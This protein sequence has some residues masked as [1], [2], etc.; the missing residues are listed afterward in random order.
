MTLINI[1]DGFRCMP[2]IMTL[3]DAIDTPNKFPQSPTNDNRFTFKNIQVNSN[4]DF[5]KYMV[6][7]YI[8]N[9]PLVGLT[10]PIESF[11]RKNDFKEY[12][13][14]YCNY[15]ILDID[16]VKSKSDQNKI[17]K[18]FKEYKVIIGESRS[19]DGISNFNMKGV[20]F[21]EDIH[22][23]ELKYVLLSLNEEI[24]EG[25]NNDSLICEIDP[26]PSR[27][28]TYNASIDKMK[29]IINNENSPLYQFDRSLIKQQVSTIKNSYIESVI[30]NQVIENYIDSDMMNL[31]NNNIIQKRINREFAKKLKESISDD[32]NT[33][34]ELCLNV[35]ATMGFEYV[36][37]SETNALIFK[38]Y[39]EIKSPGGYFWFRDS[40]FTMHHFNI[41]KSINV[42]EV[43][44][45]LPQAKK[46]MSFDID[47][48]NALVTKGNHNYI[49]RNERYL[50][51]DNDI[52]NLVDEFILGKEYDCFKISSPMGSGKS[53]V[54][55]HIIEKCHDNDQSVL[56]VT[57]RISVANDFNEKYDIKIY[58]HDSYHIN[59][60]L[61]CQYDSL[62][63]YDMRYFD[64]II[65]DEFVSV[66]LHSRNS[67]NDSSMNLNKFFN[68]FNKKLVLADAFLTG[69]E[70]NFIKGKSIVIQNNYRDDVQLYSYDNINYF[71]QVIMD[72]IKDSDFSSGKNITISCT[73]ISFIESLILLLE[74]KNIRAVALTSKTPEASK[75]IIYECF[76]NPDHDK[77]DVLIYSPTLTVGVSNLCDVDFH[78]HYDSS[79]ST[80]VISSLQMIKRT[81]K[82]KEIHYYIKPLVNYV[83]TN[84]NVL[85]D[86]YISK[87]GKNIDNNNLFEFDYYGNPKISNVGKKCIHI[88]V[89]KN[90]LEYNHKECFDFLLK[91]Q[92]TEKAKHIETSFET[93]ILTRYSKMI[94]KN[95]KELEQSNLEQY[96]RLN[97]IERFDIHQKPSDILKSI[98]DIHNRINCNDDKIVKEIISNQIEDSKFISKCYYYQLAKMLKTDESTKTFIKHLIS[99]SIKDMNSSKY[100]ELSLLMEFCDDFKDQY[101]IKEVQGSKF[102]KY[103]GLM[104]Y[105]QTGFMVRY[106]EVPEQI[107]KFADYIIID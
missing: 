71:A 34:D 72:K 80:D 69:Y 61:I 27:R 51:L 82:A 11:R 49:E 31:E 9:I 36:G 104:G 22:I 8:L 63:R 88:D 2:Y 67:L 70:D 10:K 17:I 76:R 58:N 26:C 68:L 18:F 33:I 20:L 53:K 45:K 84:Y 25:L 66:L 1:L 12:F 81:R 101:T 19:H 57:N 56:I 105:K 94:S 42:Y 23:D 35:F 59:D 95:S 62:W 89:F 96:M 5:F 39:S 86:D 54:I 14:E 40:P 73:S 99:K 107:K 65:M 21:C 16:K 47:Y 103:I 30:G 83:P 43:I 41:L 13:P 48:N 38:H 92:F 100:T 75:E 74:K 24:N 4:E 50:Q 77:F 15:F 46:I 3:F 29:I 37:V 44:K 97:D 64:V 90:I 32:C 87:V 28:A 7:N 93:N 52:E 106:Y 60:S 79:Q 102:K 91:Y 55:N 98:A 85:R 6:K 78:F